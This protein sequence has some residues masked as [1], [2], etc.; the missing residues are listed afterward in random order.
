MSYDIANDVR[1]SPLIV[2]VTYKHGSGAMRVRVKL[3]SA[4]Q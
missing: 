2:S 1:M 3:Y 4:V